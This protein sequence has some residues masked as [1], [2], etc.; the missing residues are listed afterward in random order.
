MNVTIS[1]GA[2]LTNT[3]IV[4]QKIFWKRF[5]WTIVDYTYTTT[6]TVQ[7]C[8]LRK[9]K[10]YVNIK[11]ITAEFFHCS[12]RPSVH[13]GAVDE[14]GYQ[15]RTRHH[16]RHQ[17][18]DPRVTVWEITVWLLCQFHHGNRRDMSR[19]FVLRKREQKK[20]WKTLILDPPT[21]A[22]SDC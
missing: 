5:G 1:N 20:T 16:Y 12:L 9:K 10:S 2:V 15:D 18:C 6:S 21:F 14:E 22:G 19:A 4:V 13:Y 8:L 17:W 3:I 11:L 7:C